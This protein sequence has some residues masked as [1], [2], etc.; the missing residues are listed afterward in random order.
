MNVLRD[1]FLRDVDVPSRPVVLFLDRA[2]ERRNS[3]HCRGM[4]CVANLPDLVRAARYDLG[5][6]VE[7]QTFRGEDKAT[8]GKGARMFHRATVVLGMHGAGFANIFYMRGAGSSVIEFAREEDRIMYPQMAQSHGV[9][10]RFVLT[11]RK[12]H[13]CSNV[14]VDVPVVILEIRRAL[15]RAGVKLPPSRI[16]TNA[17]RNA[18]V[19]RLYVNRGKAKPSWYTWKGGPW[20]NDNP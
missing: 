20:V 13:A 15:S 1:H 8:F 10:Y 7:V 2:Y 6:S 12:C 16:P 4:R 14:M 18:E 3:T 5:E 11:P 19:V 9:D 17:S